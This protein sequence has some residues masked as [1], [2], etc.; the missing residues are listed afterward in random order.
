MQAAR[1]VDAAWRDLESGLLEELQQ[2]GFSRDQI[3][4]RQIVYIRYYGQLEDV[5]V[6]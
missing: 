3:S 4:L 6:E 1:V 5:E 2:E